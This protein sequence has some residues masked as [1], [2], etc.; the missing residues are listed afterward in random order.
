MAAR[1]SQLEES[2][3]LDS[4]IDGADEAM[5]RENNMQWES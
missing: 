1:K 4:L 5:C 3:D 2:P